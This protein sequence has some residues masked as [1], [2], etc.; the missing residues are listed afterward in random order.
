MADS[1]KEKDRDWGNLSKRNEFQIFRI[2]F[3]PPHP[4]RL[5]HLML[6]NQKK[7]KKKN[8][9]KCR[10]TR[11]VRQWC[12]I[13]Q[14]QRGV[15]PRNSPPSLNELKISNRNDVDLGNQCLKKNMSSQNNGPVSSA[16][17]WAISVSVVS[18]TVG[19]RDI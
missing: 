11:L 1:Q 6:A 13:L 15:S 19:S 4:T 14:Q 7:K 5:S 12:G 3:C 9:E 10:N 16:H 18:T 2:L 8:P 17:F